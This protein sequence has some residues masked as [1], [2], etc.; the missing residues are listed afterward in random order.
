MEYPEVREPAKTMSKS[1]SRFWPT[2]ILVVVMHFQCG[3]IQDPSNDS[4]RPYPANPD[5]WQYKGQPVLLLGGTKD[6]NLF[7]I[8]G[9]EQ[10]LDDL[11]SV[12][13]NYLRNT[14]SSRDSGDVYPFLSVAGG[15]YDLDQWNPD[16]W[17]RFENLLV[18]SDQ[19]DIIIQIEM[20]DRFD[21]S[22]D[23][24]KKSPWNPINNINYDSTQTALQTVYPEHP[25]LDL[26]PFFHS[27]S[28]MPKYQPKLD[29]IRKYQEAFVDH[30]LSFSLKYG[31]VLYCMDNET[32]TPPEWG[33]YWIRYIR[34]SAARQGVEI[35]L[36]DMFDEFYQPQSCGVCQDAIADPGTYTFLDISQI[37][38]RNFGQNHWD[39]LQWIRQKARA[40][41][42]PI[43]NTKVYGGGESSWG[44]G[45]PADGVERFCRNI[46]GG[47]A[48][49]RFHRP[50]AG[51][52]LQPIS[53]AAI[54]SFRLAESLVKLWDLDPR[55]D[56]LSERDPNEAYLTANPG[57]GQYLAYFP[58]GGSVSI[59]LDGNRQHQ[60]K[61][62]DIRSGDWGPQD[63]I[64]VGSSAQ[65]KAPG[66]GGWLAIIYPQ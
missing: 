46:I 26:Q 21:Y 29:L 54:K 57:L 18:W 32:S 24:W 40:Y 39:T 37:N 8:S 25:W 42:R 59:Q 1:R 43:N 52:G 41:Q 31:N 19:R 60:L 20:W 4:I 22:Q 12:G 48:S 63:S 15:K 14:M 50:W 44:S 49:A 45:T 47:A 56:L 13:G 7:Q 61:W 2:L 55:Q 16:Y 64:S 36:T 27:I 28:G 38:S 11:A 66:P 5:Y 3:I 33:K 30:L 34:Q 58:D 65:I 9:L 10:H 17:R 23:F 51:S 6:D 62:I 53:K 35:Y